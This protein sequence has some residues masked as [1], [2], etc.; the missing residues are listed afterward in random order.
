MMATLGTLA[1]VFAGLSLLAVGG[2]NAMLPEI[3]RQAAAYGWA[4]PAEFAALF[5][6]AQAAPGPNMLVVTLIGWRV[7]GLPG[8]VV[9]TIAFVAPAAVLTYT[10]TGLWERFREAAWRQTVQAGLTPV[11][12]GL[13]MGAAVLLCR[14]S[15]HSIGTA[16]MVLVSAAVLLTTRLHPLWLLALGGAL[17][18]AGLLG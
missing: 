2:A 11:T 14:A 3:A 17:G 13:V 5:A 8:A 4:G 1:A 10:V 6:L 7:A 12:V 15:A 9:A 16:L 18:A